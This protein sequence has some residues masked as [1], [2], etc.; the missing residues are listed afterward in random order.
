MGPKPHGLRWDYWEP[1]GPC[2]AHVS[3]HCLVLYVSDNFFLVS[4]LVKIFT[5]LIHK[6]HKA[7]SF[8]VLNYFFF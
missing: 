7:I 3:F 8:Q 2:K 5:N 6:I 1:S 4:E